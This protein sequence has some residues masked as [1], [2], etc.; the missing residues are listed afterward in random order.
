MNF[1]EVTC[2][3]EEEAKKIGKALIEKNLAFCANIIPKLSS[4][5]LWDG[6]IK[7]DSEAMLIVKTNREFEAVKS[8][9]TNLHSYDTP[10]ILCFPVGKVNEKY[11]NWSKSQP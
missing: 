9:I 2:K 11:L 7:E 1:I 10:G 6:K 5:Y 8:E 4:Y 3:N